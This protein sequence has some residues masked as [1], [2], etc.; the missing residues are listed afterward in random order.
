M[1][2]NE[3]KVQL[4]LNF[5]TFLDDLLDIDVIYL[6]KVLKTLKKLRSLTWQQVYSDPGL[7]WEE[8]KYKSGH[9]TIRLSDSCRAIAI[10]H[11]QWMRFYRISVEHDGAYG[12]K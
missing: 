8:M 7:K 10:R 4:D 5:P 1:S 12:K 11:E 2:A 3:R 9:Y 6:K